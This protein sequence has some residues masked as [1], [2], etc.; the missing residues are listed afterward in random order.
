MLD[1][2]SFLCSGVQLFVLSALFSLESLADGGQKN[3]N[4][5]HGL[6]QL[7]QTEG[8]NI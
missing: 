2:S 7:L 1:T 3:T 8:L 6:L 4:W 5:L